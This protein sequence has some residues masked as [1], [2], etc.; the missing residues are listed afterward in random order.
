MEA[1]GG[2][3]LSTGHRR[4]SDRAGRD[5]QAGS[6]AATAWRTTM[7]RNADFKRRVRERMVRTG[8]SYATARAHL[9][10][11]GTLHVTNGD[12]TVHGL[13]PLG[14][15]ALPWR[16]VLHEGPVVPDGRALR[17]AFLGID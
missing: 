15:A 11:T 12:S 3:A 2:P 1:K 10:P 4:A 9:L 14:I 7:T 5:R 13:A 8:E 6:P 17:A 16:D